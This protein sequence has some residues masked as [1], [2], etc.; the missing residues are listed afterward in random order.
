MQLVKQYIL[1]Q[2][3]KFSPNSCYSSRKRNQREEKNMQELLF[4][5]IVEW[6]VKTE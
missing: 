1:S 4:T 6:K 3:A 2:R 5:E